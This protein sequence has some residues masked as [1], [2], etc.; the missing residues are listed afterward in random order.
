MFLMQAAKI[1][2]WGKEQAFT[3]MEV[4]IA[5]SIFSVGIL[6]VA[7]MQIS[8]IQANSRATRTTVH[9]TLAQNKLEELISL[10]YD[11]PRLEAAG[12]FPGT[13][14]AGNT[15]QET[16]PDGYKITWDIIDD[17]PVANSKHITVTV[18]GRGGETRV[19]CI[20]SS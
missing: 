13:D 12:N 17:D 1:K 4:L 19:V 15:H 18:T 7:S 16:T 2:Y 5:I 3:L 14:T 8:A 11:N 10:P 20:K 6:A 9:I